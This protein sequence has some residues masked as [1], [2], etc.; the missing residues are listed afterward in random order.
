[1][2]P[3]QTQTC[4]IPAMRRECEPLHHW[5]HK[6]L[7]CLVDL[8]VQQPHICRLKG[9]FPTLWIWALL[10]SALSFILRIGCSAIMEMSFWHLCLSLSSPISSLSHT[11]SLPSPP[12]CVSL[13]CFVLFFS[14]S[15]SK[16]SYVSEG[17][18]SFNHQ[19]PSDW[20]FNLIHRFHL[21][22]FTSNDPDNTHRCPRT[23]PYVPCCVYVQSHVR[24]RAFALASLLS[25]LSGL[26]VLLQANP[27]VN[28]LSTVSRARCCRRVKEGN[29]F[30]AIVVIQP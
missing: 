27:P 23:F 5:W 9:Q 2:H 8:G 12:L 1:M 14:Q 18:R 3:Y 30:V 24:V 10:C 21:P 13:C 28:L 7:V 4:D 20:Q 11:A 25:C 17:D 6:T 19:S 26:F 29:W 22:C 15:L 16:G